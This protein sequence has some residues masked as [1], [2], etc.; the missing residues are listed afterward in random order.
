MYSVDAFQNDLRKLTTMHVAK[1]DNMKCKMQHRISEAR[2][3]SH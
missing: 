2:S 1:H 3:S